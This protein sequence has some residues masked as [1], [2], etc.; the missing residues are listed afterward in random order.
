MKVDLSDMDSDTTES[1]VKILNYI[2]NNPDS[3]AILD[4]ISELLETEDQEV[5]ELNVR[6]RETRGF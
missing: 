2:E 1:V 5:I 3:I 6:Y 4:T